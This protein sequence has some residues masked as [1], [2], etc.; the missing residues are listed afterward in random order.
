ML[1]RHEIAEPFNI[2]AVRPGD[3]A[4]LGNGEVTQERCDLA[5]RLDGKPR[6]TPEHATEEY[7]PRRII[8]DIVKNMRRDEGCEEE[9]NVV[10]GKNGRAAKASPHAVSEEKPNRGNERERKKLQRKCDCLPEREPEEVY[11][12]KTYDTE[13]ALNPVVRERIFLERIPAPGR[14][15]GNIR[16]RLCERFREFHR[17]EAVRLLGRKTDI[18]KVDDARTVHRKESRSRARYAS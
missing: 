4:L 10:V 6:R 2:G 5:A 14:D 15:H 16:A 13:D 9:R 11:A 17:G 3:D 1:S 18:G 8:M 12:R 7:V